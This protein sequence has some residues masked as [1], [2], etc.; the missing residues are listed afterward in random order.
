VVWHVWIAATLLYCAASR[1][2]A[3]GVEWLRG[4]PD[5]AGPKGRQAPERR[6]T[7][8]EHCSKVGDVLVCRCL[9]YSTACFVSALT[10]VWKEK[11]RMAW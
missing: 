4:L 10:Q 6:G 1:V 5:A 3:E 8:S 9:C 7:W 11:R 2:P